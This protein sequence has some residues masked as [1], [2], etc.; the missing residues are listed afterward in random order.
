LLWKN[1]LTKQLKGLTENS[2]FPQLVKATI[3]ILNPRHQV[4]EGTGHMIPPV[5]KQS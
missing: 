1:I 5:R 2:I 3:M 4:G